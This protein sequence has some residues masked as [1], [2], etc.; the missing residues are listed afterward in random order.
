[1]AASAGVRTK[2]QAT[3]TSTVTAGNDVNGPGFAANCDT[4]L[5]PY[6]LV[7]FN[8][9]VDVYLNGNLLRHTDDVI[10]GTS[11]TNGDLEFTFD[12]K[13]TG[14]KPDQLHVIVHG[15]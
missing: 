3:M 6:N 12:L 5:P 1:M 8:T 13:G 11:P 10:A 14:S 15:Q 2:V 9:D 4:N 7:T